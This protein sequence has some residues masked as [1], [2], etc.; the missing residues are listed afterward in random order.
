ML[1][2]QISLMPIP[3]HARR[4]W[5]RGYNQ[6]G[7]LLRELIVNSDQVDQVIEDNLVRIKNTSTQTDL[8]KHKRLKN[9]QGAFELNQPSEIKNKTIILI[10]DVF[11]LKMTS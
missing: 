9:I 1:D 3:L 10:D 4:Q 6:S 5:E 11:L 8:P 7:L 2:P